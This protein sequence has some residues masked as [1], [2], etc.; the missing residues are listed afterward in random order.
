[1]KSNLGE[2]IKK[3]ILQDLNAKLGGDIN[4]LQA[5]YDI[6]NEL[7]TK[8]DSLESSVCRICYLRNLLK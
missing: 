6:E 3:Q 4:N 1:M 8:R 2:E 5:A 7:V